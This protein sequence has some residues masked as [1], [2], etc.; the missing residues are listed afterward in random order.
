MALRIVAGPAGGGKS[1]FVAEQRQPGEVLIDFTSLYVALSGAVR[2]AD[3]RYPDREA[4]DA[5]LPLVAW[6]KAA[7]VRQAAERELSGYVTTSDRREIDRLRELGAD[8]ELTVIDP[9]E[10]VT[11]ARLAD[12]TGELS[13]ECA[14]ALNRWY[15]G[16]DG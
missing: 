7:A 13:P 9:G 4:G 6:L 10:E 15:G 5:L 16:D 1:Q 12:T 11:R 8:G 2:G 3:G 14:R